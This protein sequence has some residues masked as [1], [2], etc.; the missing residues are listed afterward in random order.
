[1]E[2]ELGMKIMNVLMP[3]CFCKYDLFLFNRPLRIN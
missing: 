2:Y 1:M 3:D